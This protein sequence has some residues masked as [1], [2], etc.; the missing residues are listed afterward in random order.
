MIWAVLIQNSSPIFFYQL[1]LN[2]SILALPLRINQF[3]HVNSAII[4]NAMRAK[5]QSHS[6]FIEEIYCY[7]FIIQ[8]FARLQN[9]A[10]IELITVVK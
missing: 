1:H 7:H 5:W 2:L 3:Y 8:L 10:L 4:K 6:I 9:S